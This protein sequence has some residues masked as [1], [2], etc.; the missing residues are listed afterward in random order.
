MIE[1]ERAQR[2]ILVI[3]S[4][5]ILVFSIILMVD[6]KELFSFFASHTSIENGSRKQGPLIISFIIAIVLAVYSYQNIRRIKRLRNKRN[7]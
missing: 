5:Y 3:S 2:F 4:C 7:N 1:N 6:Y